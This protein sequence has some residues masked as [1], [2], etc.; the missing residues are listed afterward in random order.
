MYYTYIIQS[1]K[2]K[3]KYT[4]AT[5]NLRQRFK[6]HNAKK[7]KTTKSK[8][9]YDLIWYCAFQEKLKAY[10]FERYLKTGSGI[11]FAKKHLI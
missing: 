7:V 6:E 11:A 1:Q 2:N 10:D 3:T 9:P 8:A 5:E 4:G